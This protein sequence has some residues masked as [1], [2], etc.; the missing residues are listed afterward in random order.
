MAR[1]AA[2]GP[3]IEVVAGGRRLGALRLL[4]EGR[5]HRAGRSCDQGL[6]G[7]GH[8]ARGWQRYRDFSV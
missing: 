5:S 6:S 2:K 4:L 7:Q 3:K 8:S 1:K